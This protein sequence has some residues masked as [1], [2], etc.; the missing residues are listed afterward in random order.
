MQRSLIQPTRPSRS[1]FTLVELLVVI[2]IILILAGLLTV[3]V[4]GAIENARIAQVQSELTSLEK[5]M[6]DFQMTFHDYPPS[7]FVIDESD[8][9][10]APSER[11]LILKYWPN[12][13]FGTPIAFDANGDGD[14][15]DVIVLN[16]AESLVFFLG[17]VLSDDAAVPENRVPTGFS[18]NMAKP[19]QPGGSR[20]GP[21]HEFNTGQLRESDDFKI[22][23][24]PLTSSQK[25]YVYI[26]SD[27]YVNPTDA[28]DGTGMTNVYTQGSSTD[29]FWK[30]QTFQLIS[31]GPDGRYGEGGAFN[32]DTA[33]DTLVGARVDE[34]DNITN[35]HQGKLAP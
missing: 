29:N 17:G 23:V 24:D 33:D 30:S 19:F 4:F 12:Y 7:S 26:H 9:G 13:D 15:T 20:V 3:A 14:T 18:K 6:A 2:T 25:A 34:R 32:P 31:A 5:G 11:N 21:F 10:W 16:G 28:L 27:D 22:L 35:F 1:G 8:M